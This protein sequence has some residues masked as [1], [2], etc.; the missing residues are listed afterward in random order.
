[1]H[2]DEATEPI[3]DAALADG[4]PFAILPCC[5]NP[6]RRTA[7]GLPVISYEQYLDYLQAKHPAIRRARLA[8]FEGR[9]VVL[10]YDP[11]VPYCEPC[12]E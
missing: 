12:E 5:A 7:V 8:K 1:M 2:P 10:W 11:L 6:H 4:K 3:V 9:N